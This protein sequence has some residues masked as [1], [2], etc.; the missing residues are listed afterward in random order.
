VDLNG[1]GALDILSGSYSRQDEDMAGLLQVLWGQKDGSFAP[2]KALD[3]SDGTPLVLPGEED[4][5]R[6]CTRAFAADL[7]GDGHLDLVVGNFRGTFAFVRGAGQGKFEP[8]ATWLETQGRKLE[9]EHHGD[10]FLIDWDGDGDLDLLSGSAQGGAFLC[11]NEGSK[12]SPQFASPVTLIEPAGY[13]EQSALLGD[14]HL[15]GPSDSTR[16]WCDDLN[17]DGRLDLLLGDNVTLYH[18][19]EGVSDEVAQPKLAEWL[20][21]MK[22]LDEDDFQANYE[23]LVKARNEYVLEDRTG[24]VWVYH[25]LAPAAPA[26]SR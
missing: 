14:A 22:R 9:V 17:G 3:A 13:A 4:I 26:G 5:D 15:K 24:F 12:S 23:R 8:Q 25:Q 1:D 16:V 19:A 21:A 2:A 18:A 20:E 7:D 11:T 6:I 10:P